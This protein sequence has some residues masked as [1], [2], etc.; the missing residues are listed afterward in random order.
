MITLL[1]KVLQELVNVSLVIMEI[2]L[3]L[4]QMEKPNALYQLVSRQ[5]VL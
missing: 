3:Q 4:T 1:S 5:Q 2:V